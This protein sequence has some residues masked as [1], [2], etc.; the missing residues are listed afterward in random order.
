[1]RSN[2]VLIYDINNVNVNP[3]DKFTYSVQYTF[4]QYL[5][6]FFDDELVRSEIPDRIKIYKNG[7]Y[8]HDIIPTEK[9]TD[10]P[11]TCD[12][13]EPY[14]WC[15]KLNKRAGH[16]IVIQ[17]YSIRNTGTRYEVRFWPDWGSAYEKDYFYASKI[18]CFTHI[19]N[20]TITYDDTDVGFIINDYDKIYETIK[21]K[22]RKELK[23]FISNMK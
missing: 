19:L 8:D 5:R 13:T 1:M 17:C 16:P 6:N 4:L 9:C 14:I 7:V 22:N 10:N 3:D 11:L 23:Q 18:E 12:T 2:K 20:K 21:I 15:Q